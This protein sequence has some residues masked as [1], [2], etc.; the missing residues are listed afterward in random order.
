MLQR[1]NLKLILVNTLNLF[2]LHP[3]SNNVLKR[4]VSTPKLYFYDTGLYLTRWNSADTAMEGAM[5]GAVLCMADKLSAF[6][7]NNLIVP[8]SLI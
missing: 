8:I 1:Q 7:Q 5:S 3:Y 4:T 2:L 6:D